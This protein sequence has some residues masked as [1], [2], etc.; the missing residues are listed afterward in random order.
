MKVVL[1]FLVLG[2]CSLAVGCV[3]QVTLTRAGAPEPPRP[4]NCEF[5]VLT[6]APAGDY[7]EVG[8]LDVTAAYTDTNKLSDFKKL[9][10]PRVCEAGGDTVIALANGLGHYIKATV[11]KS[12][13]AASAHAGSRAVPTLTQASMPATPATPATPAPAAGGCTFDTQCKGDRVCAKGECVEPKSKR[14][15]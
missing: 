4:A 6:A 3:N 14:H 15:P 9:I 13:A 7:A 11:L 1:S 12:G 5:Q 2:A 8:T 10:T